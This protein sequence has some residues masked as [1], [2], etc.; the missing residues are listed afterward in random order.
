[1]SA[2]TTIDQTDALALPHGLHSRVPERVYHGRTLG[3]ASKSA[4]DL[5]RRSP[6]HYKAWVEGP[7]KEPTDAMRFGS[8]F[9]CALLEP[10]KFARKYVAEPDFGDCRFKENKARR[11]AWRAENAGKERLSPDDIEAIKGMVASVHADPY[12]S[13]MIRNGEPEL[14]VRWRDEETGLECKLRA[15]Y[16]VERHGM[17]V[18]VKSVVD[19]S[20]EGFAKAVSSY[21]Y[22]RQDAFYRMGFEAIGKRAEHFVFVAVEKEPPYAVGVYTLDEES[23]SRGAA[24][25]EQDMEVLAECLRTGKWP[26][27]GPGIRVIRVK[28]WAAA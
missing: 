11:D 7:E 21:G 24:S 19:A 6:A 1:M 14:T 8:A 23:L 4:L 16:Y 20:E 27:Y 22:H 18:D 2:A 25:I 17:I 12:A 13:K 10:E 15:D 5:V 26:A 28:P 9:H 3:L